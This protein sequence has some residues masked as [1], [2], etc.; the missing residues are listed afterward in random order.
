MPKNVD[1]VKRPLRRA[2]THPG[3]LMR[4]ILT[5]HLKLPIA[6]AARRMKVSRPSLYAVL[7]GESAVT[8][9]MALRFGRLTGAVP[10]LYLQMQH[11]HDLWHAEARLAGELAD[12]EPVK[13]RPV[14]VRPV[15]VRPVKVRPGK[16]R[17]GKARPTEMNPAK[18]QPT[19]ARPAK[20]GRTRASYVVREYGYRP[21]VRPRR[22]ASD[23]TDEEL[24]AAVEI[25]GRPMAKAAKVLS[26]VERRLKAKPG[27]T[28]KLV[29][30]T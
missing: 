5:E 2:P 20:T 23:V 28:T 10:D 1:R 29:P 8:A 17:P 22:K 4:E 21:E 15:K 7:N 11:R 6:E 16:A 9:E 18:V 26:K 13:V 27:K 14:K 24:T 25:L 19:K 12:I 30:V 3:E